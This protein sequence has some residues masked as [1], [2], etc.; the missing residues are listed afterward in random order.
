MTLVGRRM[1]FP[2]RGGNS[3][4]FQVVVISTF[5][6]GPTVVKFYFANSKLKEKHF[7]NFQTPASPR[8]PCTP[9]S[10]AHANE[11]NYGT[12]TANHARPALS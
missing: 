2:G 4:L 11:D 7:S 9:P 1:Y 12:N 3:G 6:E 8:P 10:D 5:L